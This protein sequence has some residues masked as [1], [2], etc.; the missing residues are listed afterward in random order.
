LHLPDKQRARLPLAPAAIR[1]A[2]ERIAQV[3]RHLDAPIRKQ[4][5]DRARLPRALERPERAHESRQICRRRILAILHLLRGV[6]LADHL[7]E[8]YGIQVAQAFEPDATLA[9][10]GL[11]QVL[12]VSRKSAAGNVERNVARIARHAEAEPIA[13]APVRVGVAIR[14][15]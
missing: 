8:H 2:V 4:T 9:A 14:P 1:D 7:L 11:R 13:L 3:N 6:A 10:V 12:L 5:L 15:V